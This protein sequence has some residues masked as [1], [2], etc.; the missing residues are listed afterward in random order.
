MSSACAA[1][2][3]TR[4]AGGSASPI[5]LAR[6]WSKAAGS[7]VGDGGKPADRMR[8]STCGTRKRGLTARRGPAVTLERVAQAGL[9]L[10]DAL[11]AARLRRVVSGAPS[12]HATRTGVSPSWNAGLI[13][14]RDV[15]ARATEHGVQSVDRA[16]GRLSFQAA[17]HG[18]KIRQA[19]RSGSPR[20]AR[21]WDGTAP[22]RRCHLVGINTIL[23]DPRL[24]WRTDRN[25]SS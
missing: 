15:L 7:S 21:A 3:A 20:P 19:S 4:N 18:C 13:V 1:P 24:T 8:R 5:W 10:A 22:R 6:C 9:R 14:T 25:A 11:I 2:C 12:I 16:S 23:D 17:G